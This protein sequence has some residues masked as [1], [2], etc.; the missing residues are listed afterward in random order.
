MNKK[1]LTPVIAITLL[2]AVTVS[3][4]GTVLLLIE[5]I[6]GQVEVDPGEITDRLSITYEGC[7]EEN[8]G[9]YHVQIRNNA[10]AALDLE[11]LLVL[12]DGEIPEN[13]FQNEFIDPD[14]TTIL[15]L[16]EGE[17]VNDLES[18]F[19]LEII[20]GNEREGYVCLN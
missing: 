2:I 4:A 8:D 16:E 19:N 5:D 17:E 10:E 15:E 20:M 13:E 7:W 14:Q 11:E 12:V 9:E 1:G 6:E 18:P 3:A